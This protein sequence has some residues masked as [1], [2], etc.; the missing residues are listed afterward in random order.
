MFLLCVD[1]YSKWPEVVT[2]NTTTAEKTI[3][4]LHKIFSRHGLSVTLVSDNGPQFTS[5]GSFQKV[6]EKEWNLSQIN[7]YHPSSNG[8]AECYVATIKNGL[9]KAMNEPGILSLK[10]ANFLLHY[11]KTSN[12]TTGVSPCEL[13]M[14]RNLHTRIHLVHPRGRH[15]L[16]TVRKLKGIS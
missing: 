14:N 4:A 15:S 12:A 8:Q 3:E 10:L 16:L 6:Y 11:R 5:G 2:M 9:H 1:A 13:L 7:T